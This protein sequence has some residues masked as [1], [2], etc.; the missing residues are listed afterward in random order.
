MKQW[1]SDSDATL[2]SAWQLIGQELHKFVEATHCVTTAPEEFEAMNHIL[3]VP[4]LLIFA[5]SHDASLSS[6]S[7]VAHEDK[8]LVALWSKLCASYVRIAAV[9]SQHANNAIYTLANTLTTLFHSRITASPRGC[10]VLTRCITAVVQ[11][12]TMP[13][14]TQPQMGKFWRNDPTQESQYALVSA[15]IGHTN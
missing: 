5:E 11:S 2:L 13:L 4:L 12:V 9:K 8:A 6:Q 14:H 15:R 7:T 10:V 1:T 3:L